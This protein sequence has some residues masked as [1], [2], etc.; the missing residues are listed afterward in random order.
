MGNANDADSEPI[1]LMFTT[2]T[3][4]TI[5]TTKSYALIVTPI[6]TVNQRLLIFENR[7]SVVSSAISE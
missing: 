6:T 5:P 2:F 7:N 4:P 1:A 3:E